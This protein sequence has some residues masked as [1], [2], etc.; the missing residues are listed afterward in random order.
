MQRSCHKIVILLQSIK[1][2]QC[3]EDLPLNSTACEAQ[4]A[5]FEADPA[6]SQTLPATSQTL[7]TAPDALPVMYLF[8]TPYYGKTCVNIMLPFPSKHILSGTGSLN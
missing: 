6:A 7:P 1:E 3:A 8:L 4:S 5:A 2:F